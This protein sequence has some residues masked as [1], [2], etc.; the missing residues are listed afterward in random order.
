MTR[1]TKDEPDAH[2]ALVPGAW[3]EPDEKERASVNAWAPP[4]RDYR[5][6][7][8]YVVRRAPI[9]QWIPGSETAVFK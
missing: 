3:D 4:R 1:L 6:L 5:L 9:G 8:S 2:G 7:R